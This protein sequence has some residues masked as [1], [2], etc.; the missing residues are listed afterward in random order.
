MASALYD[1]PR[2]MDADPPRGRYLRAPLL[3]LGCQLQWRTSLWQDDG[4]GPS[5]GLVN[6]SELGSMLVRLW[7]D[8]ETGLVHSLGSPRPI[9]REAGQFAEGWGRALPTTT[10]V[11]VAMAENVYDEAP[12]AF[13]QAAHRGTLEG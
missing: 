8:P 5:P 2:A 6:R 4:I 11:G 3:G 10:S 13:E 1:S 7:Q 9:D 12:W